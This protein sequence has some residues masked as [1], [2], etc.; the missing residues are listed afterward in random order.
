MPLFTP[1]LVE[2]LIPSIGYATVKFLLEQMTCIP[3]S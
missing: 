1:N 2:Y 3:V